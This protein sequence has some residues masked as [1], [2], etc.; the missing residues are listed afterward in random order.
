MKNKYKITLVNR[1]GYTITKELKS[2]TACK[3]FAKWYPLTSFFGWIYNMA[4]D[5]MEWQNC[6]KNKW[7]KCNNETFI[8]YY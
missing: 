7:S 5:N 3:D 2:V 8:P 4:S 6:Y 1:N